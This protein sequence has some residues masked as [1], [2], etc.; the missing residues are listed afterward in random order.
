MSKNPNFLHLIPLNPRINIFFQNSCRVTFFTSLTSN[1]MQS[2]GKS[3][4]WSSRYWKTDTQ[5][6]HGRGWFLGTMLGKNGVQKYKFYIQNLLWCFSKLIDI[7]DIQYFQNS[8]SFT[9]NKRL[10]VFDSHGITGL[11]IS[12]L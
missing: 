2:F 11:V 4:E 7:E 6:D 9:R 10:A 3:N 8:H 5:T 12:V 1:F